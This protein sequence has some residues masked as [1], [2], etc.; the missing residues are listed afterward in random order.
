MR[1]L[2]ALLAA[3][4]LPSAARADERIL[5]YSSE[6]AI[7]RDASLLVTEKIEVQAE[8]NEIR[9]GIFRDFPVRYADRL[10]KTVRVGF[11][12]LSVSRDGAAEPHVLERQGNGL[13][14][15]IG[16]PDS[17]VPT[18]RHVYSISYR[19]TRQV[20]RFPEFDEFYWNVTGNG[21]R[22]PIDN[23][24]VT[25]TLPQPV[26]FGQRA[27]YTGPQG[28]TA[29]N[30]AVIAEQAGRISVRTTAPLGAFE[31]LT[32]AVAFPRGVLP[33]PSEAEQARDFFADW[34]PPMAG[35]AALALVLAYYFFAWRNAGR[36]PL[37]GTVVPIFAPPDELTPAAMRFVSRMASDSRT[38]SAA[39]V[40]LGVR[41]KL[42]MVEVD[43]GWFGK[44]HVLLD[45]TDSQLDGLP[46]EESALARRLFG[47]GTSIAMKQENYKTFQA[48]REAM[49]ERLKDS[50]EDV[51][52]VRNW[53]WSLGGLAI[54]VAA[55]G[56]TAGVI[57]AAEDVP[58]A[59]PLLM[60][61]CG[62]T[63]VAW[64]VYRASLLGSGGWGLKFAAG[65]LALVGL[66]ATAVLFPLALQ[67]GR[68]LPL[69]LPIVA[70]PIVI[71]AF[72]WMAAP[73]RE[74][75]KVMDRIAGF[76]QYLSIAEGPRLDRMHRPEA[77]T[78]ELFERYLPYAVALGVENRWAKRF[79]GVLE[80]ASSDPSRQQGFGWYS[81]SN[82]PWTDAGSF[83]RTVGASLA[84]AVSSAASSPGSSSGSGGGG[85]S[86]GGGG[87]GGGGG[88]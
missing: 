75:R 21:W 13:R 10:G 82:S 41:G 36:G 68:L 37:A 56:I 2:F 61:A 5:D 63:I 66:A 28:S 74:G 79:Q 32:V 39:L 9:H 20:G 49:A 78:P 62:A 70:L 46:P 12:L 55:V 59:P 81:G 14:I 42:R 53:R 35:A 72:W 22:F 80:A 87:G 60:L 64:L 15:R 4:L 54:F 3:L 73:T 76:K 16:S 18:G 57:A 86:G 67:S 8:G 19:T 27:L 51:L 65:V 83:S 31:G 30:A 33:P 1:G 58:Y 38:V 48:A 50:Y 71:S 24:G 23:A 29:S 25:I 26:R 77:D 85:S 40:S 44:D 6:V 45:R 88:W 43:G 52:F 69:L 84:G 17:E 47:A 34:A 7:Q 11:R